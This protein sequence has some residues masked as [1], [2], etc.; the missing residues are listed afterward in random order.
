MSGKLQERVWQFKLTDEKADDC[1]GYFEKRAGELAAALNCRLVA[2]T[3]VRVEPL[4]ANVRMVS[5]TALVENPRENIVA[6]GRTKRWQS[7]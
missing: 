2:T 1:T 6:F 3:S 5:G 4:P 7:S